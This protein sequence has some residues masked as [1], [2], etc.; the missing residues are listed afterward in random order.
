MAQLKDTLITGDLRVTGDVYASRVFNAVWNDYAEYRIIKEDMAA[1]YG[2][3]FVE[4]GD[5]SVS[6]A[7]KRL[8]PGAMIC[9]DTFGQIIGQNSHAIPIGVAGRVLAYPLEPREQ[10]GFFIGQPVCSGPNGT[11]SIMTRDEVEKYPEAIIGYVSAIPDY[12]F[13]GSGNIKV[14]GR[15]WIKIK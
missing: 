15:I 11:V 8:Q 1:P 2:K 9:S 7:T 14:D 3:V 5:D 12:D 4:N 10:Y 13:W 6:L